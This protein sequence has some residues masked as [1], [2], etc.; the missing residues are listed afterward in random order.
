MGFEGDN[1]K[2]PRRLG[3][4]KT[5]AN[6]TG[7]GSGKGETFLAFALFDQHLIK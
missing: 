5:G 7:A 3:P 6:G 2:I 1:E 4:R